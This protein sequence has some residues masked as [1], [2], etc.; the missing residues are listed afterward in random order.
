MQMSLPT[1]VSG[2]ADARF[3]A[4]VKRFA[5]IFSPSGDYN[6]SRGGGALS[7]YERGVAVID[8]WAGSSGQPGSAWTANTAAVPFSATKG[9]AA[10]VL[11]RLADRGLLDYDE[12]IADFWP[13]FGANGKGRI[14][15]RMV[16][17]HQAG[18]AH[19][20]NL[21]SSLQDLLDHELMESRLAAARPARRIG[22]AAYHSLT[23]GWLCSGIARAVTGRSMAELFRSEIADP[24]D[25]DGIHLGSPPAGSPTTVSGF[26]GTST[27]GSPLAQRIMSA[28]RVVPGPLGGFLS[29][30]YVPHFEQLVSGANPPILHAQMP[31][32]NGVITARALGKMYSALANDGMTPGGRLLS[33]S[34]VHALGKVQAHSIDRTLYL[35]MNWRLGYHSWPITGAP[36][37]IG[38]MGLFGS[39]GWADRDSGLSVGFVHNRVVDLRHFAFDQSML[40]WL[41]PMILNA[42][43]QRRQQALR[44]A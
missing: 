19:L 40:F 16:L 4:P 11:H 29:S 44:S 20:T 36:H 21:A 30:I 24:I 28:A 26:V 22:S 10:T 9:V 42:S 37:A 13:E 8:I 12:P 6:A 14:T 23:Y 34:T 15:T 27:F 43:R 32:A 3:S 18:L 7:V 38:H 2:F 25:D 17:S 33:S 1:G 35:P 5:Q 31:A 39:G 41:S